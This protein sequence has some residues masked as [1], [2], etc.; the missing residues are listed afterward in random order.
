MSDLLFQSISFDISS[1]GGSKDETM[2]VE[3]G[4]PI[5]TAYAVLT[6]WMLS[7]NNS[8]HEISTVQAELSAEVD[9]ASEGTVEVRAKVNLH[10][11]NADDNYSAT[12][13]GLVIAVTD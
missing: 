8:D 1:S 2:D 9:D 5:S 4:Q 7:Y 12:V 11:K 10:D 13:E 3:F 6:G